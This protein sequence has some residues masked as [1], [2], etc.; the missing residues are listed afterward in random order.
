MAANLSSK[1][2]DLQII[3]ND[4]MNYIQEQLNVGENILNISIKGSNYLNQ[5]L[6][7]KFNNIQSPKSPQLKYGIAFPITITPNH[8]V[9]NISPQFEDDD[10]TNANNTTLNINND[11]TKSS[12]PAPAPVPIPITNRVIKNKNKK[13]NN[14]KKKK[15]IQQKEQVSTNKNEIKP[16][17]VTTSE[18]IDLSST[19]SESKINI[20]NNDNND[21]LKKKNNNNKNRL[22]HI[23]EQGD[24][25]KIEFGAHIDGCPI[26][27]CQTF[28]IN[29]YKE[30]IKDEKGDSLFAVYTAT[31]CLMK[32]LKVGQH[33][34]KYQK[35]V[36]D[37]AKEFDCSVLNTVVR[38]L[39]Y[40][41]LYDNSNDEDNTG[42]DTDSSDNDNDDDIKTKFQNNKLYA[43]DVAMGTNDIE[44]GKCKPKESKNYHPRIFE[45]SSGINDEITIN[46]D[47]NKKKKNANYFGIKTEAGKMLFNNILNRSYGFPF[48]L[49]QY[50]L[51]DL[52]DK[53]KYGDKNN[54]DTKL[55]SR[56][57]LSLIE[58]SKLYRSKQKLG[59]NECRRREL[60]QF[61]NV[62]KIQETG[63]VSRLRFTILFENDE[64]KYLTNTFNSESISPLIE[65]NRTIDNPKI[66][67]ILKS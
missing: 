57:F 25:L 13:K 66:I 59:L 52:F 1:L 16:V 32:K 46:D 63:C 60:L 21:N 18:E 64:L 41:Q 42:D 39:G 12:A 28:V 5:K 54:N 56:P 49:S 67:E 33:F 10:D 55:P 19:L 65:S 44:D 61:F 9:C 2:E 29:P 26:I 27:V 47:N 30:K 20:D 53:S 14:N 6:Y 51:V 40:Y 17:V 43:I 22:N 31:Q 37:V 8:F 15:I 34:R 4:T 23:I 62:W 58:N 11:L 36:E 45:L 50:E 24:V 35:L 3:I 38:P 7:T 48:S